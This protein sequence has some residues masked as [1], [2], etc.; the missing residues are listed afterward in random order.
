MALPLHTER[1][2]L[3]PFAD[4]DTPR[5]LEVFG[6]PEVMRFVGRGVPLDQDRLVVSQARVLEHWRTHGFGTLALVERA[7]GALVG[8]G[9]LQLL[10]GGPDVELTYTLAR[11][12]WGRGYATEAAAALLAWGFGELGLTRIVGVVYPENLASQRVLEKVGMRRLGPRRCYGADLV[13]YAA[14]RPAGAAG[15]EAPA[16][17]G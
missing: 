16:P 1:L 11:A 15:T 7:S 2:I 17:A 6:D 10:E 4:E 12:V 8:E 5:L 14:E 13:E 9:G 3:R